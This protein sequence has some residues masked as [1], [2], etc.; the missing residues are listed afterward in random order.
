M[1]PKQD[2]NFI[3]KAALRAFAQ[4]GYRR[5]RMEDVAQEAGMTKGNLYLYI[6]D[7]KSLYQE[8]VA[9][10][11]LRWQERVTE[12]SSELED[13]V[14]RFRSSCLEA[15]R[16]L[17]EDRDLREILVKDPAIFPLS[18]HD[19]PYTEINQAS[20]GM[21]ESMITDGIDKGWFRNVD[22]ELS[23]RFLFSVYVMFVI[24]T[25]IRPEEGGG[26][27]LFETGLDLV[28]HGLLNHEHS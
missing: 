6:K 7:K 19:D 20:I 24:K 15:F 25:Y 1:K 27:R 8:A 16:H 12:V 9:F 11:L 17:S 5:T 13:P 2:L 23:A 4:Y 3:Y 26:R 10:G 22:S 21:L 28:L 14:E 18:S